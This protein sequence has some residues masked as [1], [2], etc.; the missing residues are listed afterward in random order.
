MPSLRRAQPEDMPAVQACLAAAFDAYRKRYTAAAYEDTILSAPGAI[1]RRFRE[2]TVLVADDSSGLV[3]GTI[4]YHCAGTEGHLRG[5]AVHPRAQG[6]RVADALLSAAESELRALG[7]SRVTLGTTDVL[8]RARKFYSRHGYRQTAAIND[9][10]GMPLLEYT[11]DL[12]DDA[13]P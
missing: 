13:R 1:E 6:T 4:A 12:Q 7:C 2:M 5:M 8:D 10:F 9:F 3:V 11:K